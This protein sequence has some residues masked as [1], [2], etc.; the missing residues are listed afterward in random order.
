MCKFLRKIHTPIFINAKHLFAQPLPGIARLPAGR[1]L[2]SGSL[3]MLHPFL[4]AA[5][6][7][8]CGADAWF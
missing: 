2:T 5:R 6:L 1:M 7:A 8:I 4:V 3:V